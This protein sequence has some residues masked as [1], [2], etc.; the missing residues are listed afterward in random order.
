MSVITA[1]RLNSPALFSNR[2]RYQ[3]FFSKYRYLT[4]PTYS[5]SVPVY[6]STTKNW[7]QTHPLFTR[8]S[9]EGPSSCLLP[10]AVVPLVLED[11]HQVKVQQLRRPSPANSAQ[12][13]VVQKGAILIFKKNERKKSKFYIKRSSSRVQNVKGLC[14]GC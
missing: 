14:D 2:S 1:L 11:S 8:S 12:A 9:D 4:F 7:F 3:H 6:S 10:P 5:G 13:P